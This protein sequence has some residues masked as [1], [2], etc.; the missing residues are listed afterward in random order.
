MSQRNWPT[1]LSMCSLFFEHFIKATKIHCGLQFLALYKALVIPPVGFLLHTNKQF[2]SPSWQLSIQLPLHVLTRI[3]VRGHPTRQ[4]WNNLAPLRCFQ[5]LDSCLSTS[6]FYEKDSPLFVDHNFYI[7]FWILL[8]TDLRA[9]LDFVIPPPTTFSCVLTEL[10][11]NR[12]LFHT[13]QDLFFFQV[14]RVTYTCLTQS[15]NKC[16]TSI[17]QINSLYHLTANTNDIFEL[18]LIEK[19]WNNWFLCV[20]FFPFFR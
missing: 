6:G 13:R 2:P 17:L 16:M 10:F 11:F 15:I 12:F 3:R 5:H 19:D 4:T 18:N 20:G 7:T 9:A 14:N 8:S 1:T